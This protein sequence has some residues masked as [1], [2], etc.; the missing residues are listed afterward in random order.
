VEDYTGFPNIK[1]GAR[2]YMNAVRL[3][4][5]GGGAPLILT[6]SRS[7]CGAL[8]PVVERHRC[9]IAS[10]N[11]QVGGFLHTGVAPALVP[12]SK[13]IFFG[14]FDL[15]GGHIEKNARRVLEDIVGRR[16]LKMGH[17]FLPA[18]ERLV[19]WERLALT[20]EQVEEHHLPIITKRDRRYADGRPHEAVETE[21]LRQ[22]VLMEIL[23]QR[24]EEL[25]P[26]SLDAVCLREDRERA[27]LM[28]ALEAALRRDGGRE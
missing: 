25:I 10:I 11:G 20:A 17:R 3:D 14:D 8:R 7:L 18:E 26:E 24:L 5:W 4:P 6:E 23:R 13:V 27:R 1:T 19:D 15:A 2:A 9:Q 21:A 22:G 28:A 16:Y 12:G